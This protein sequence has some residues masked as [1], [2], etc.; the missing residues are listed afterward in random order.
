MCG[1]V[2]DC[3]KT[4]N[5]SEAFCKCTEKQTDRQIHRGRGQ[6]L[7]L[8]RDRDSGL[9]WW[10]KLPASPQAFMF[11]LQTLLT[12]QH[13]VDILCAYGPSEDMF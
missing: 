10:L 4:E 9:R 1:I 13:T 8:M 5:H 2:P 6:V 12:L 3:C 7:T 11:C